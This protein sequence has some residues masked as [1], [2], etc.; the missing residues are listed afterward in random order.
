[1]IYMP[2]PDFRRSAKC[3]SDA[4]LRE[5]RNSIREAIR[6]LTVPRSGPE[7]DWIGEWRGHVSQLLELCE[8]TLQER[9]R[10]GADERGV[11]P[12][13]LDHG[14]YPPD[15]LGNAYRHDQ[16]KRRL[17]HLDPAHYGKMNWEWRMFDEVTSGEVRGDPGPEDTSARGDEREASA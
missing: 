8:A 11:T 4:H 1:M 9:R 10:R 5:Q 16:D 2:Y 13:M 7:H 3:L 17:L 15:W 12:W 14:D 6:T